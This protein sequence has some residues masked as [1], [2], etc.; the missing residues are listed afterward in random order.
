[1]LWRL[2]P[3]LTS[4]EDDGKPDTRFHPKVWLSL[5]APKNKDGRAPQNVIG[6]NED[7]TQ[8]SFI[9]WKEE[10]SVLLGMLLASLSQVNRSGLSWKKEDL[11]WISLSVVGHTIDPL[12]LVMKTL[13]FYHPLIISDF[14]VLR[15]RHP[16]LPKKNPFSSK[17]KTEGTWWSSAKR[18]VWEVATKKA[19]SY[20]LGTPSRYYSKMAFNTNV[21]TVYWSND[22]G[23]FLMRESRVKDDYPSKSLDLYTCDNF[24]HCKKAQS[25]IAKRRSFGDF[26]LLKK[27]KQEILDRTRIQDTLLKVNAVWSVKS[28]SRL[29]RGAAPNRRRRRGVATNVDYQGHKL[30]QIRIQVLST[31]YE[32]VLWNNNKQVIPSQSK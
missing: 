23:R 16:C 17:K 11:A 8:V 6:M 12:L 25:C 10:T 32:P 3:P 14:S 19:N 18:K 21:R 9:N 4:I 30:K 24:C 13:P 7:G 1:M 22:S 31:Y 27:N 15:W 5:L 26:L 20:H 28:S 2:G 29:C